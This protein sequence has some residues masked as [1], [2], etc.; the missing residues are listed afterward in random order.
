MPAKPGIPVGDKWGI[1]E[2]GTTGSGCICASGQMAGK[3]LRCHNKD[4]APRGSL[5]STP[6]MLMSSKSRLPGFWCSA[7]K[8]C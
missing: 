2:G 6:T 5:P 8:H 4:W 7:P 1:A 3:G